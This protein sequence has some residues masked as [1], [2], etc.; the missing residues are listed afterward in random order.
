MKIIYK[1]A[2]GP[3]QN[4]RNESMMQVLRATNEEMVVYG[5]GRLELILDYLTVRE[6]KDLYVIVSEN[7]TYTGLAC[8]NWIVRN[9]GKELA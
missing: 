1:T 7:K 5:M 8:L 6:I 2:T 3:N 9:P 4:P